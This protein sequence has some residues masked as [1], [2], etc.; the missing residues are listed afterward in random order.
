MELARASVPSRHV[1]ANVLDQGVFKLRGEVFE[2]T[3]L[4]LAAQ[5]SVVNGIAAAD[6][7]SDGNLDLF[8]GEPDAAPHINLNRG[9]RTTVKQ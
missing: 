3:P 9:S 1:D 5:T 6:F 2:F 8:L 7:N 4:P